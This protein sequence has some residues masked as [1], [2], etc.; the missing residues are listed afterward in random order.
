MKLFRYI[1][2]FAVLLAWAIPAGAAPAHAAT[3]AI[4]LSP[5]TGPAGTSVT[6]T[7]TGFPKKTSGTVTAGT[8]NAPFKTSASGYFTADLVMPES[9]EPTVTVRA[10]TAT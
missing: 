2:C 6:I 9:A 8:A 1:L 3:A 7:G 4:T 5:N 10:A